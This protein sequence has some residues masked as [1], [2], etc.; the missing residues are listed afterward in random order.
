MNQR[1]AT[2][3]PQPWYRQFWPWLLILIPAS[4]VVGGIITLLLALNSPNAL[5]EDDYYKAGLAIN[6]QKQRQHKAAALHLRGLLRSSGT[7][8]TLSLRGGAAL[9]DQRLTLSLVHATRA[10]LDRTLTLKRTADGSYATDVKP[11]LPGGWYL[12]VAPTDQRWEIRTRIVV[13][14]PFQA[15]LTPAG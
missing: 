4:T 12:R 9:S 5:V 7:R 11:L 1:T 13:D 2:P 8:L 14:G 6:Q 3:G 10:E 15:H